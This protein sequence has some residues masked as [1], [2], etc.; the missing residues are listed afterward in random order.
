MIKRFCDRCEKEIKGDNAI[1]GRRLQTELTNKLC[2]LKIEVLTS[3]DG[4]D[5]DGHFCKYCVIEAVM[6]LDDRPKYLPDK[7]YR[8]GRS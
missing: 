6:A 1:D 3:K 2:K 5:N 7:E 8:E 4:V